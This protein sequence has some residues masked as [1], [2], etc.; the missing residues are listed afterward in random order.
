MNR[1]KSTE[2]RDIFAN[3]HKKNPLFLDKNTKTLKKR[4]FSIA[5]HLSHLGPWSKYV[6]LGAAAATL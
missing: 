6:M 2:Y 4:A 1:E 5:L 3:Y